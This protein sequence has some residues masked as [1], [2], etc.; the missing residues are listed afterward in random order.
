MNKY[1][2]IERKRRYREESGA[3]W[4]NVAPHLVTMMTSDVF[5][6]LQSLCV[7]LK[8]GSKKVSMN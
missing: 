4:S 7:T 1:K 2:N 8:M 3:E 5:M 6:R